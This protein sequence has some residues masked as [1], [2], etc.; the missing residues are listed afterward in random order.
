MFIY[1]RYSR[2]SQSC[3]FFGLHIQF[4]TAEI[5][6]TNP[7]LFPSPCHLSTC[8]LGPHFSPA[9]NPASKCP[10]LNK[11]K[12]WHW[13]CLKRV[14]SCVLW[15]DQQ[16]SDMCRSQCGTMYVY[17]ILR[18]YIDEVWRSQAVKFHCMRLRSTRVCSNNWREHR[19]IEDRN[20]E[21][22][23]NVGYC[24]TPIGHQYGLSPLKQGT[25]NMDSITLNM[26]R[27]K[28]HIFNVVRQIHKAILRCSVT[29]E[30][31]T[32]EKSY[33]LRWSAE[34]WL[35]PVCFIFPNSFAWHT[36]GMPFIGAGSSRDFHHLC[37][38]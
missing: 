2:I 8:T 16:S 21:R 27:K 1:T 24:K 31:D 19:S 7:Q 36:F 17:G 4:Y 18:L 9:Q 14:Q 35:R 23:V 25:E 5:L 22:I 33:W 34:L 6:G 32:P 12:K 30:D 29:W 37:I 3:D 26:L 15:P 20:Q 11:R 10:P 38:V 28:M 13:E